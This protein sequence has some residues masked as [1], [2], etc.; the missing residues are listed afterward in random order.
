MG[1]IHIISLMTLVW[2]DLKTP[3][4]VRWNWYIV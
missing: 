3:Y 1:C 4:H 2:V